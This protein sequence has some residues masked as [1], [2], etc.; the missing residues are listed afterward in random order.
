MR[1][2]NHDHEEGMTMSHHD[3]E[4]DTAMNRHDH[5]SHAVAARD[6]GDSFSRE[7][8]GL[9]TAMSPETVK[10]RD[11]DVFDLR[12]HPVRKRID[13]AEVRMLGYNGSTPVRRCT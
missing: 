9:P 10:L 5:H 8:N 11:G 2:L 3:H 6:L 12:I 7:T 1:R 4:G 13:D